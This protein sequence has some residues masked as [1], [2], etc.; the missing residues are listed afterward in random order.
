MV[1]DE[2]SRAATPVNAVRLSCAP[3]QGQVLDAEGQ[4]LTGAT[5]LLKGTQ[6]VF[7]TD[8]EGRFQLTG[9]LYQKQILSVEAAGHTTRLLPLNDC[10]LPIV[11][12]ERD[13]NAKIK[14]SGKRAGQ[15]TRHGNAY[16][17]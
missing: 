3:L 2:A 4:P 15:V 13:P 17:Q 6:K 1:E 7:I 11:K 9:P 10:Q 8:N 12:L 16:L 5:L 14:R